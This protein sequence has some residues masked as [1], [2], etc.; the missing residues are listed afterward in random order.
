MAA[1]KGNQVLVYVDNV[2]IGCLTGCTFT[3][4][5]ASIDVTCKDNDGAPQSLP[6][7]G[8]WQI[9]FNGNFKTDSTYG[10]QQ[11]LGIRRNQTLAQI[12]YGGENS[13]DLYIVGAAYLNQ[14]TWEGPLNAVSTFSGQ[15]DGDGDWEYDTTT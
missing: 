6:T 7:K 15:F 1:V 13:G 5:G 4:N 12:K 9:T 8:P 10:L 11:L 14:I 2:A 3:S